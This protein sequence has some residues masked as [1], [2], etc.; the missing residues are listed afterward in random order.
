MLLCAAILGTMCFSAKVEKALL[1]PPSPPMLPHQMLI[2]CHRTAMRIHSLTNMSSF[3][4]WYINELGAA[5]DGYWA[6][7]GH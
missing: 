4:C 2:Y 7:F 5:W 1:R 6:C 3:T